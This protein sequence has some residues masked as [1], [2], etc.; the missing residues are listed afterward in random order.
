MKKI[1]SLA[2]AATLCFFVSNTPAQTLTNQQQQTVNT[3]FKKRGEVYFKFTI[4]SKQ[5]V[6][7]LTKIISIDNVENKT[8]YAFANKQGFSKFLLLNY[9]YTVL[10]NPNTLRKVKMSKKT[11]K[12]SMQTQSTWD[13]YPTYPEYEAQM[14]Q[15]VTSYPNL[16]K[17]V[18]I[19]TLPSGR[20]LLILKITDN[21]NVREN[22]PQFLYTSS[23]HGDEIAGYVGMLHYID[24]LLSNYGSDARVTGLV[25]NME[26]WINPLANPDG[27]FAGGDMDVNG[28]TRYN[29]NNIDLNRNYPDPAAGPHPDG[30]AYQPE[31]QAFMAFA[32]S[33]H[34]VMAAN[35]HGGSE[36]INYPWD[37]WPQLHADDDWY[38]RE[39][40]KYAD[41]VHANCVSGYFMSQ[42][43]GVT[44]GYAWY[45]ITGGRQDYMNYFKHC[46][47]LT[48]ELSMIK[49]CPET[50]LLNNWE[51]NYRSWLNYMEEALHGVR[52]I[53]KDACTNQP[54]RAQVFVTG[55]DFDS[56]HV[57]SAIPIGDYYRPIIDGTYSLTYSA[58]GYQSQTINNVVVTDGNATIVN[59]SLQAIL[60][61]AN[62]TASSTN[63][64]G[65]VVS[66]TD[67][68]G[69]A[70]SWVWSFGDGSTSTQQ[71]PSHIYTTNGTYNVQLKTS[72]CVGTDSLLKT[73]Y[74]TVT[75]NNSPVVQPATA[76]GPAAVTLSATAANTVNWYD[77]QTGGNLV[78]IG[79]SYTTPTLSSSTTYYVENA[80]P[81]GSSQYVGATNNTIGTGGFYTAGTYHYLVFTATS[82]FNL[83]SVLVNAN[84]PGNRTIQL[85]NS[86]G[87]VL[88]QAVVNIPQGSNRININFNVPVGS[89]MQL[90]VAGNCDL[91]R[92]NMGGNYPYIIN[93]V[94]SI[95]GNSAGNPVYYYYFYDWE[96]N[97]SCISA[98]VP[99]TATINGVVATPIASQTGNCLN[100]S[101]STGNQWYS[102]STGIIAGETGAS[103]CPTQDGNYFV[104]ASN[105]CGSD[106][107]NIIAF[108]SSGISE[109]NTG[110]FSMYPN[111]NNGVFT[112]DL[113]AFNNHEVL[114]E[115]FNLLGEKVYNEKTTS[116]TLVV[117]S[118]N[119]ETGIYFLKVFS[120][121]TS[122]VQKVIV[123]KK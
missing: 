117:N 92:N 74:L 11:A 63:V 102:V 111:P 73:N 76:C 54:I 48:L 84:T 93:G 5:E 120:E 41:T 80:L 25:N 112:V 121:Q 71:N 3:L 97:Q 36:L 33:M 37:T 1:I 109:N 98:R 20:K 61:T 22:E 43:N 82:S 114:V 14:N 46:R 31:T 67:L 108:T 21:V 7:T 49:I 90:G 24:Y 104:A 95:T 88:Q 60:P 122:S 19:G 17:L 118:T 110:T 96:I 55:H 23:M 26:I 83:V 8:V 99:V 44:N 123:R 116:K 113:S 57:Y 100:S 38:Q 40:N 70:T 89:D 35:L 16:C 69:S 34:F 2:L 27:T 53:I 28:A 47:E 42:G 29:A 87:A 103:F 115:L 81:I 18:N 6:N 13:V 62:F 10:P 91:Y 101:A 75:V 59:V 45:T 119:L 72:N 66:F 30:N 79:T 78:H 94:V 9:Q 52:G 77:A 105:A 15:F 106:S 64:C 85:R 107:S 51:Y 68:S 12:S 58:P 32:D 56:S 65:G 39:S 86:A 50:D 4:G